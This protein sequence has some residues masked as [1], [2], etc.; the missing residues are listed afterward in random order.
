MK[1]ANRVLLICKYRLTVT[2]HASIWHTLTVS[3]AQFFS[4][5]T[6]V[7][8]KVTKTLNNTKYKLS[9][10]SHLQ[11]A[12]ESFVFLSRIKVINNFCKS[13]AK[14]IITWSIYIFCAFHLQCNRLEFLTDYFPIF[15]ANHVYFFIYLQESSIWEFFSW[16]MQFFY[17]NPLFLLSYIILFI[18]IDI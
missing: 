9:V 7:V 5:T 16:K 3:L 15:M 8:S 12:I 6:S 1:R 2:V 18:L 4:F 13:R 14:N 10:E 17:L 11:I